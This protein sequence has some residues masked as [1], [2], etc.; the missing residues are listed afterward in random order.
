MVSGLVRHFGFGCLEDQYGVRAI[1]CFMAIGTP[2][3]GGVRLLDVQPT[4]ESVNR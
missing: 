1:S 3:A 4:A 2:N